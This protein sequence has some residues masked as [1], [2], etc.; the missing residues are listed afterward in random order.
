MVFSGTEIIDWRSQK[1]KIDQETK[2]NTK[3]IQRNLFIGQAAMIQRIYCFGLRNTTT[4][5]NK[6]NKET[7]E[8]CLKALKVIAKART[9]DF[10]LRPKTKGLKNFKIKITN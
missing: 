4:T 2:S 7:H 8:T 10:Q 5:L 3:D 9:I 6:H 1:E